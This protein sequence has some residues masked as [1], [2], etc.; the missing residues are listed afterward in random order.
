MHTEHLYFI[1]SMFAM[2]EYAY[3]ARSIFALSA[4]DVRSHLRRPGGL[5]ARIHSFSVAVAAVVVS[6]LIPIFI[7]GWV[8]KA[9]VDCAPTLITNHSVGLAGFFECV[10]RSA[11]DQLHTYYKCVCV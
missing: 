11:S 7:V 10:P 4:R 9:A 1:H 8:Y 2:H 6:V 5:R 3:Y